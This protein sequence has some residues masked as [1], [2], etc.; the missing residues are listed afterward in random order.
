VDRTGGI[1]IITKIN[2]FQDAFFKAIAI[3]ESPQRGL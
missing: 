3:V 2:R 1:G